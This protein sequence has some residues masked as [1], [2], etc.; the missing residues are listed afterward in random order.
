MALEAEQ[1]QRRN[2]P[3][4]LSWDLELLIEACTRIIDLE[5]NTGT[6][7]GTVKTLQE[8]NQQLRKEVAELGTQLTQDKANSQKEELE[9]EP[10]SNIA[11]TVRPSRATQEEPSSLGPQNQQGAEERELGE[12]EKQLPE[13]QEALKQEQEAK[14]LAAAA[15]G[16]N[17]GEKERLQ[18]ELQ[19]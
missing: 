3:A 7:Q 8:E 13:V 11:N 9:G 19:R 1:V 12:Q 15:A 17:N 6:L 4:H 18:Q 14:A 10:P 5:E 2:Q 16:E